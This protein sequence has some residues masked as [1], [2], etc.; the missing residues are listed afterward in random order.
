MAIANERGISPERL[1]KRRKLVR[2]APDGK[3]EKIVADSETAKK[4]FAKKAA[5]KKRKKHIKEKREK[6]KVSTTAP[7]NADGK[8]ENVEEEKEA[9]MN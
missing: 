2:K 3:V 4:I 1:V 7:Q 5:L 9:I 6:T 8:E